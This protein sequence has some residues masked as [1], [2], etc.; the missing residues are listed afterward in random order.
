MKYF[1]SFEKTDTLFLL[2]INGEPLIAVTSLQTTIV[3]KE[4]I[5]SI[6]E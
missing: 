3:H 4:Q 5:D 1:H 6:R 2:F